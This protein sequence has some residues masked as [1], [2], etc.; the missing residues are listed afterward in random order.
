MIRLVADTNIILSAYFWDGLPEKLLLLARTGDCELIVTDQLITE[1]RMVLSREKFA[2]NFAAVGLNV[3]QLIGDYSALVKFVEPA[4]IAPTILED[5]P[6]D[7][8]LA[9]AVGGGAQFIIPAIVTY[10]G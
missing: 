5:P 10:C 3:D 4:E 6:D 1:L 8:V 7:N 9:C 2:R